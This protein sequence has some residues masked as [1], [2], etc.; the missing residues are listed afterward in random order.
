MSDQKSPIDFDTAD[1]ASE[2]ELDRAIAKETGEGGAAWRDW[3]LLPKALPYLRPYRKLAA[4]SILVTV[5]LALVAL[6]EPWPLAFVIDSVLGT[7]RC[8]VGP[9][10]IFGEGTGALIAARGGRHPADHAALRWA[11]RRSTSI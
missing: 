9:P 2:E 3:K 8:R 4:L 6:A 5:L 11:H 1:F 10:A 7:S